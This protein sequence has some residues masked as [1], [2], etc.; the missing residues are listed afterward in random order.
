MYI[1][2]NPITKKTK[3]DYLAAQEI[4]TQIN[5]FW[6][7]KILFSQSYCKTKLVPF[8]KFRYSEKATK[9]INSNLEILPSYW[10][11]F[12]SGEKRTFERGTSLEQLA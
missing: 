12:K 3:T 7:F 10:S 8:L 4:F 1:K 2:K 5:E 6:I 11:S 9:M